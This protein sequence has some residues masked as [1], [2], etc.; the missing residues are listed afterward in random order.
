M[1]YQRGDCV[2]I[3]TG[4]AWPEDNSRQR[5]QP[6]A[7]GVNAVAYVDTRRANRSLVF[8]MGQRRLYWVRNGDLQPF[9]PV[10]TG[11]AFSHKICLSCGLL[12]PTDDFPRNQTGKGDRPVRRPRCKPC[13][14][15]DSGP[16]LPKKVRDAYLAEHGPATGDLWQ[17]PICKK[18]SVAGV[19]A[20]IVVDHDQESGR[21]RGL[22]CDSCNT[23]LGRFKN[24]EDHLADARD[25]LERTAARLGEDEGSD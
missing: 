2:L 7:V 25:Y 23:G 16:K 6:D 21:P 5:G 17:C 14:E 13:F 10:N 1:S 4:Q 12:K 20:R 11:D 8:V 19:N 15:L 3:T 24:G 18:Y 9:D 22:I